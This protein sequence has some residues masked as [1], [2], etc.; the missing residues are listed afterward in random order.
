VA[1]HLPGRATQSRAATGPAPLPTQS[2]Y[3]AGLA[4]VLLLAW[5]LRIYKLSRQS[6]SADEIA[7]L[8]ASQATTLG[9]FLQSQ[10]GLDHPPLYFLLLK[11]WAPLAGTSEFALRVPSALA[12]VVMVGLLVHAGQRMGG[13]QLG[14]LAG[15]LA[16]VSP[17]EVFFGQEARGYSVMLALVA[18][19]FVVVLRLERA[20]A[21][22]RLWLLW[23][24][25]AAA[26]FF[27][28]YVSAPALVLQSLFLLWVAWQARQAPLW[29]LAHLPGTVALAAWVAVADPL[30]SVYDTVS[31]LTPKDGV[32][33]IVQRTLGALT[34]G[35]YPG[36][37]WPL[38][39]AVTVVAT[40]GGLTLGR[41]P[42][43]YRLWLAG[44]LLGPAVAVLAVAAA[45]R[46]GFN[47][48]Y[49][50]PSSLA[51]LLLA[52]ATLAAAWQWRRPAGLAALAVAALP[53]VVAL[54]AYYVEPFSG[55]PDFRGAAEF[56]R[57]RYRTGDVVVFDAP[58]AKDPVEWYSG[59]SY[60][61]VGQPSTLPLD[62]ARMEADLRGLTGAY[63]RVWLVRWQDW[64][65]DSQ[66]Q[67]RQWLDRNTAKVEER[68]FAY[69]TVEGYLS[70]D[71][72]QHSAPSVARPLDVPLG[73]Q[74]S[75]AGFDVAEV[76][77]LDGGH[78]RVTLTWRSHGPTP[79]SF[80]GFVH[81]VDG[82]GRLVDQDDHRPVNDRIPTDRWER[83]W[84]VRDEYEVDLPPAGQAGSYRLYAGMYDEAGTRLTINGADHV[85]LG[86]VQLGG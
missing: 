69:V 14:L 48:R 8:V 55:R 56:L 33:D 43:R 58:W 59:G 10:A 9:Q 53:M 3:P 45:G 42:L 20:P 17:F 83:G 64:F 84:W 11:L 60:A 85:D 40:A 67:V 28:E 75:L 61:S 71:P 66:Q 31:D 23:G 21:S 35:Q 46:L 68:G 62:P 65:T 39:A 2:W 79:V 34:A 26:A 73:G 57:D 47:P 27:T 7:T 37:I 25:L 54:Q 32:L 4:L 13:A 24:G 29:L 1:Q 12:A 78:L 22:R 72:V 82:Q 50:L 30:R 19:A 49:L 41:L 63:R 51:F 70:A 74:V 18:G 52:G 44:C 80:K 5:F 6:L 36:A 76:A 16:A 38:A 77:G 81:L 86:P 15:L